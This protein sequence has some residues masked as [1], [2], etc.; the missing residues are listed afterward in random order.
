MKRV[1]VVLAVLV[2]LLV[3]GAGIFLATFD[4]DRYRPMVVQKMQEALGRPVQ[5]DRL[6]LTWDRGLALQVRGL[7]VFADASKQGEPIVQIEAVSAVAK[8]LPLLHKQVEISTVVVSRPRIH[9]IRDAQGRL[10]LVGAAV[11]GAPAAVEG[12]TATVGGSRVAFNIDSFFLQDGVVRWTDEAANPPMDLSL[13]QLEV[14][15]KNISLTAPVAFSARAA[16]FS[17]AQNVGVTGRCL[18]PVRSHPGVLEQVRLES[19]LSQIDLQALAKAVPAAAHAGLKDLGGQVIV[20]IDKVVLDPSQLAQLAA[21]VQWRDGRLATAG[22]ASPLEQIAVDAT[23]QAGKLQLTQCAAQLAGGRV[24]LTG[25]VDEWMGRQSRTSATLSIDALSLSQLAPAGKSND[26]ALRG[27]LSASFQGSAAGSAW[28]D[29][30]RTLAGSGRLQLH[31]GE[32]QNLN[33]LRTI[34]DQLSILPG[35]VQRLQAKL[36][37]SYRAKL[38]ERDTRLQPID[39][40]IAVA[41]GTMTLQDLRVG[42]DMAEVAGTLSLALASPS[43][44]GPVMISVEPELS[45]AIVRSV[46]ELQTLADQRGRLQ[47]PATVRW[48]GNPPV[49][50]DLQYIAERVLVNKVGDLL[51]GLIN[52]QQGQPPEGGAP[53]QTP[54][55]QTPSSQTPAPD[56]PE[57]L[58][59]RFLNRVI[60][61]QGVSQPQTDSTSPQH[62]P[63]R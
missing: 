54:A 19:D 9:L 48:P 43:L 41:N 5:L 40:A 29:L 50:P 8:L 3:A 2:V 12:Q 53:A 21:T 60:Q 17:G 39:Q 7:R 31:D 32:I 47:L 44:A 30:A 52:K 14:S 57:Q 11:A 58:L 38:D 62:S 25:V 42:T 4:A 59:G 22:L 35:L 45:A 56:S 15:L 13:S 27:H 37:D 33:I 49:I 24:Q 26:P 55:G 61:D 1:L 63:S 36:P 6:A 46:N 10:N 23:A 18:L 34:F 16:A 20:A 28:P 51:Q